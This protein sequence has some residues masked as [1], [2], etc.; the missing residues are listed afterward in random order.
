MKKYA[1]EFIGT[2]FLVLTIGLS[3]NPVAIGAVLAALVYM[4]GYIS[5]AHYN[6]AITLAIWMRRKMSGTEA[7]YYVVT[8]MVAAMAA[9][10]VYYALKG[11]VMLVAP[12][13]GVNF[14]VALLAEIIFTFLLVSVVLHTAVS[15][16]AKN[17]DYYGLAIGFAL[18]VG[19]FS[20]GPISG[21]AFNPAVGLGPNLVDFSSISNHWVNL[22]LY[23]VGP[24]V[25]GA[26][27]ALA[28]GFVTGEKA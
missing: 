8:Q 14:W 9:A 15:A 24:L 12:G 6:P 21:G 2:F 20:V 28:F 13:V 1:V 26:I 23:L 7:I 27:A 22:G 18:L 4:G 5:G 11:S 25:G 16:K 3:G 17:N 19:A 10:G